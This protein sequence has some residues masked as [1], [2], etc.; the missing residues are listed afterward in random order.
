MY[1][2]D[3]RRLLFWILLTASFLFG[4]GPTGWAA[5]APPCAVC[6][7]RIEG[8]FFWFMSSALTERQS[9]CAE[10]QRLPHRCR[11]C[12][13]PVSHRAR[14]LPDGS[15]LCAAD[16]DAA[17]L[18]E[19]EVTRICTEARRGCEDILAGSG[20]VPSPRIK[21]T[22]V[23][24]GRL[25]E[26]RQ[27]IETWHDENLFSLTRTTI[28]PMGRK[29]HETF[30]LNGLGPARLAAVTAREYAHAW[31]EENVTNQV[32][33]DRDALE[34]FCD[35]VAY[36]LM[37]RKGETR[38]KMII[39]ASAQG[40]GQ[41]SGFIQAEL[42]QE[43]A[44]TLAWV[45]TGTRP[46]GPGEV[47]LVRESRSSSVAKGTAGTVAPLAWPPPRMLITPV[48][49]EIQLRGISGPP[50]R[51]LALINDAT[52]AMGE[53]CRV[54]VGSTNRNVR[55][56]EVRDRSVLVEI[57]GQPQELVLRSKL[58]GTP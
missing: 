35:L 45:K 54:R 31:V 44:R 12:R 34:G 37:V 25:A 29:L 5:D 24:S 10:C 42:P 3:M 47:P 50:G 21:M 27:G 58:A 41:V 39:L 55:C 22:V 17:V 56:L 6:R 7:N 14:Q 16:F 18:D 13:L 30:L 49:D 33:L 4:L 52:V 1:L 11:I 43:F 2:I 36:K 53:S 40:R 19:A 20:V 38:E 46:P 51:R 26:L 57:D 48:P 32:H 9:V 8:E 23:S 28:D 15:Y